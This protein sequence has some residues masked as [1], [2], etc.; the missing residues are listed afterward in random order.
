MKK[1]LLPLCINEKTLAILWTVMTSHEGRITS[2]SIGHIRREPY[3]LSDWDKKKKPK[4]KKKK[5]KKKKKKNYV[6][7]IWYKL[8]KWRI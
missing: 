3:W 1:E 2:L 6:T 8:N 5:K 4:N 7:C